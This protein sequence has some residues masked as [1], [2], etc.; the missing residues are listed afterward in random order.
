M[1]EVS[2]VS[3]I[4]DDVLKN[5][6]SDETK[7][8]EVPPIPVK[9]N[10]LNHTWDTSNS[11]NASPTQEAVVAFPTKDAEDTLPEQDIASSFNLVTGYIVSEGNAADADLDNEQTAVEALAE[12]DVLTTELTDDTAKV[13]LPNDDITA[14]EVIVETIIDVESSV[15]ESNNDKKGDVMVT[16]IQ[17]LLNGIGNGFSLNLSKTDDGQQ[18]IAIKHSDVSYHPKTPEQAEKVINAIQQR[19]EAEKVLSEALVSE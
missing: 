5:N 18:A 6:D 4:P 8:K 15:D 14:D 16:L 19:V 7:K 13:D 2:G 12:N 10:P 3:K 1:W 17:E 11:D 9:V